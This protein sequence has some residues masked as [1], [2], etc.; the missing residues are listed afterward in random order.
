MTDPAE[1]E[2]VCIDRIVV[3]LVLADRARQAAIAERA[4]NDPGPFEATGDPRCYWSPGATLRVLFLD[5]DPML[6]GKVLDAA[7]GWTD[8]AN[9]TFE[10]SDDPE[11]EIRITFALGA[12]YSALGTD[13]KLAPAGTP[14][15]SLA[16]STGSP[17]KTVN[18]QTRHEFGHALGLVHEHQHPDVG[19]QWNKDE[20]YR[21][22]AL[23][24]NEWDRRTVDRN[25]FDRYSRDIHK[26]TD[27]DPD[28]VML[29]AVPKAW[30]L[31]G[32]TFRTNSELSALDREFIARAYPS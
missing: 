17:D 4:D 7:S 26:F 25:Y 32:R 11:S 14:T 13:S 20:I 8:H 24:P 30:T 3:D 12:S 31:D 22:M 29:Y 23:P 6:H 18:T 16:L 5:G 21:V 15:M 2:F 19:I 28:S 27:F 10:T 1:L 9:V